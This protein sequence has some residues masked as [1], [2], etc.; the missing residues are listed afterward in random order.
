ML[1]VSFFLE[2]LDYPVGWP[3]NLLAVVGLDDASGPL[4]L[5]LN[6]KTRRCPYRIADSMKRDMKWR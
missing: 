5:L 1:P 4:Y 3:A 2:L 6:N